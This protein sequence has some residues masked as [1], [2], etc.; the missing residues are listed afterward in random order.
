MSVKF[1]GLKMCECKKMTNIRYEYQEVALK[2]TIA[3][4]ISNLLNIGVKDVVAASH[5]AEKTMRKKKY[6]L[7]YRTGSLQG[8][9]HHLTSTT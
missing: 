2:D 5:R 3:C 1:P 9:Q 8:Q 4:K 6:L 7:L